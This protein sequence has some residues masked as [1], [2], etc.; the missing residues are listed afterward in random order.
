VNDAAFMRLLV[1]ILTTGSATLLLQGDVGRASWVATLA[2]F[3]Y[4]ASLVDRREP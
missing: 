3:G 2:T 1:V 4:V